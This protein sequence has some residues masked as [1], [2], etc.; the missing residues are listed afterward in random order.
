MAGQ[1]GFAQIQ[2]SLL[3]AGVQNR[4]FENLREAV[5]VISLS[6]ESMYWYIISYLSCCML[7]PSAILP[8]LI[9]LLLL[10]CGVTWSLS[11]RSDFAAALREVKARFEV[12]VHGASAVQSILTNCW[13]VLGFD[14]YHLNLLFV[15]G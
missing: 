14:C 8:H 15:S 5:G 6:M 9:W 12:H 3:C 1:A 2:L 10:D 13:M 4:A 11:P 7:Q